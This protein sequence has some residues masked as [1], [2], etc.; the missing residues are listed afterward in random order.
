MATD[1]YRS[2]NFKLEID[3]VTEGHFTECSGLSVKMENISY[4]EAGTKHIAR[5]I[6][7]Q[8][9][10]SPVT[11]KYGMTDSQHLWEWLMKAV[12]GT[13]EPKNAAIILLDSQGTSEV[14]RWN[15]TNAWPSEWQGAALNPNDR[16]IAIESLTLV[17]DSLERA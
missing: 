4:P 8:V 17:F 10:Y 2:Y 7:G 16:S 9:D 13:V 12:E 15:L 11:L 5:K 3:G 1:P 6:P 14:M